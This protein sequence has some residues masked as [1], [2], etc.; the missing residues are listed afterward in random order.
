MVKYLDAAHLTL[1][2]KVN[3]INDR[4][5]TVSEEFERTSKVLEMTN[6]KRQKEE[7][8]LKLERDRMA[9]E[10]DCHQ[11]RLTAFTIHPITPILKQKKLELEKLEQTKEIVEE[12]H[13]LLNGNPTGNI[14]TEQDVKTIMPLDAKHFSNSALKIYVFKL[15]LDDIPGGNYDNAKMEIG[16]KYSELKGKIIQNFKEGFRNKDTKTI[17]VLPL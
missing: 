6:R 11:E 1:D 17:R 10:L 14:G 16:K 4:I 7:E 12:F 5:E 2:S 9:K 8:L 3:K 13:K 15:L